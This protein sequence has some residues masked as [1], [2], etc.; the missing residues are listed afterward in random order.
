M[1]SKA[2]FYER[3]INYIKEDLYS[4]KQIVERLYVIFKTTKKAISVCQRGSQIALN[5]NQPDDFKIFL[6]S[7]SHLPTLSHAS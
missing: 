4:A 1:C 2:L 5:C 3:K 7:Q 6:I